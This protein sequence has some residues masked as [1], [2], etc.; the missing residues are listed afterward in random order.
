MS[1]EEMKAGRFLRWADAR[2]KLAW[3]VGQISAGRTVLLVSGMSATKLTAK[4]LEQ[5]KATRSGLY[6]KHGSK[7][8]CYNF[9][10]I[11]AA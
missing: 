5:I 1:N 10:N 8:L 11:T 9:H 6:V 2:R 3:I 7:W 4:H